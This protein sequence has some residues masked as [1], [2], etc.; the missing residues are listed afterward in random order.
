MEDLVSAFL[1]VIDHQD[2]RGP[3]NFTSPHPVRNRELAKA[4]GAVLSRPSFL[5]T[6][7]FLLRLVL[8]EFGLILLKGQ[9]V[10][11]AQLLGHGFLFRYPEILDALREV[12][13]ET[14]THSRPP[15][16]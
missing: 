15:G 14:S 6:P 12:V 10:T 13:G 16:S 5:K 8:G 1:F 2:I 11:P 3:V 4:L 9:R 7:G